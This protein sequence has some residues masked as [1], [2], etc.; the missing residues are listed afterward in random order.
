MAKDRF[1]YP[2]SKK[3]C[4]LLD[5][6]AH[7][8]LRSRNHVF[9]DWLVCMVASLSNGQMEEE[10]MRIIPA[11][12]KGEQGQRPIDRLCEAFAQLIAG[13]AEHDILGDLFTWAITHREAGQYFTPPLLCRFMA[14]IGMADVA[15]EG[16]EFEGMRV[17]D[18]CCGSGG[19]LLS[20][21]RAFGDNRYLNTYLGVD[22]D[23][24]CA[25]M[26]TLNLALHSLSGLVIWGDSLSGEAWGGFRILPPGMGVV[27]PLTR[28]EA[29][30]F[31]ASVRG[32]K[33]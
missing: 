22:V 8:A 2:E 3:L 5:R 24:R 21:A 28:E 12:A 6:V 23:R 30:S 32:P 33:R 17:L 14:K 7:A 26:T 13:S 20:C 1:V 15:R 11:Y 19:M 9:E 29:Q 18:P 27:T 16:E 31:L 25:L 10:Y 4:D